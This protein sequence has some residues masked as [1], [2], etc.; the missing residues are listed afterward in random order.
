MNS[1]YFL[2]QINPLLKC[3]AGNTDFFP[4]PVLLWTTE[5]LHPNIHNEKQLS[6]IHNPRYNGIVFR[7]ANSTLMLLKSRFVFACSQR[8]LLLAPPPRQEAQKFITKK[9]ASK[10]TPAIDWK[11]SLFSFEP[12]KRKGKKERRKERKKGKERKGNNGRK[13]GRKEKE[14]ETKEIG[15]KEREE[16]RERRKKISFPL[17]FFLARQKYNFFYSAGN[18][19]KIFYPQKVT[20]PCLGYTICTGFV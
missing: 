20:V 2:L 7:K 1:T 4:W 10:K 16:K 18:K 17:E 14:R 19:I 9:W 6:T 3:W 13:E 11:A 5:A 8:R 15:K 12:L